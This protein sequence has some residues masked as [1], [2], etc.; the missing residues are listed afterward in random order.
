[1]WQADEGEFHP[2]RRRVNY[3]AHAAEVALA[4]LEGRLELTARPSWGY[5][6]RRGL[7]PL[8]A[9]DFALIAGAM[10]AVGV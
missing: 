5:A 7:V 3:A 6:L 10:G 2:W 9:A 1:M 8:G 4:D